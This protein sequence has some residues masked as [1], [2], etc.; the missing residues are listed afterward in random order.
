MG[1][2]RALLLAARE[3]HGQ[4]PTRREGRVV[5]STGPGAESGPGPGPHYAQPEPDLD[6]ATQATIRLL[7]RIRE[8][9]AEPE[10][11]A[12]LTHACRYCGLLEASAEAHERARRLDPDIQTSVNHTY[13]Q[14]GDLARSQ[15][16][17]GKGTIYLD[18]LILFEQG[19][20]DDALQLVKERERA[21]FLPLTRAHMGALRA[22]IEGNRE[23]SIALGKRLAPQSAD[24]EGLVYL[25]R[26]L[27]ALGDGGGAVLLLGKALDSGFNPYRVLRRSDSSLDAARSHSSFPHLLERARNQYL[28]ARQAFVDAG[29]ERLLGVTVRVS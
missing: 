18:A 13:Y 16:A 7:G 10:S 2:A 17:M 11:Y 22:W 25:A 27:S 1:P 26:M 19:K 6:R 20:S 23:E 9:R 3:G 15:K 24:G 4:R 12:A 5:L 21:N 29:G 28:V 8:G 14:L